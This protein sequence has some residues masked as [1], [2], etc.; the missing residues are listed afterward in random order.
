MSQITIRWN[1]PP[2]GNGGSQITDYR[3]YWDAGTGSG[4]FVYLGNTL[5]YETYTVNSA[6]STAFTGG[7]TYAFQVSSVNVIGEG[8]VSSSVS[9]IAADVPTA[10]AAPTLVLQSPTQI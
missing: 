4:N 5:G 10:P 3:V 6:V 8:V 2:T 1:D 9:V 7:N